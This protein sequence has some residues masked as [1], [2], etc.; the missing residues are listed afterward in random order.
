MARR[1][2]ASAGKVELGNDEKGIICLM[3]QDKEKYITARMA[4][5]FYRTYGGK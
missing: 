1:D 2:K 4:Q 3:L 5:K